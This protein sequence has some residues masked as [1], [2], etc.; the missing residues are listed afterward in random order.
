[1]TTPSMLAVVAPIGQHAANEP[2][3][4]VGLDLAPDR[5]VAC[6]HRARI[7][8]E[9]VVVEPARQ[10][11]KRPTDVGSDDVEQRLRGRREKADVQLSIQKE[12]RHISAVE[13]VLEVV[14]RGALLL[15]RLVQLSC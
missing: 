2:A 13:D 11:G 6:Q 14:G 8:Q 3:A 10:I 4:V 1:M 5:R 9:I 12:C 7:R 15:D